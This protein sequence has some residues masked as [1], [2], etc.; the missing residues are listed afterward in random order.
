VL[1]VGLALLAVRKKERMGVLGVFAGFTVLSA[2]I[3]A[4]GISNLLAGRVS[5]TLLV[6]GGLGLALI[7]NNRLA[8]WGAAALVGTFAGA[9]WLPC[10]GEELGTV[11]TDAQHQPASAILL[12][13]VYLVGVMI[14]LVAIV[15]LLEYVPAVRRRMDSAWVVAVGKGLMASVGILVLVDYYDTVLST[16]ARWSVL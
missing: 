11:L 12:L 15:A 3:R 2:W 14:P 6:I 7:V 4:S 1:L 8:G 13:G 10:V 16:L 5:T 9:T